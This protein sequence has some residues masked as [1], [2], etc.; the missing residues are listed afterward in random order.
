MYS[1]D[2]LKEYMELAPSNLEKLE[3]IEQMRIVENDIPINVVRVTD[4]AV[5]VDTPDDL[6]N[7]ITN[8]KEHFRE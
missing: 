4:E 8:F 7:I 5:S 3:K 1:R 2:F 6:D